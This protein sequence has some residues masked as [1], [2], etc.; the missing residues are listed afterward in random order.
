MNEQGE[1]LIAKRHPDSLGG[2]KWEFPGGK[3]EDGESSIDTLKRELHEEVGVDVLECERFTSLEHDYPTR[4]LEI[5][6]WLVRGYSGKAHGK[7]GQPVKWVKPTELQQIDM[8]PANEK[9][10][11]I[12]ADRF[13]KL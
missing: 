13:S 8:L 3:R 1:C 12:L 5:D 7:E 6:V 10:I 2:N 4:T 9:L 11:E